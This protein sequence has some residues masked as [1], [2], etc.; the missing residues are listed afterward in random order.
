MSKILTNCAEFFFFSFPIDYSMTSFV[1][2]FI[3]ILN[4]EMAL[5]LLV[6]ISIGLHCVDL[7]L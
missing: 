6:F 5:M 4:L 3:V 2:L 7:K 1:I